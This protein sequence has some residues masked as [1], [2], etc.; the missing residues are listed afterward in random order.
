MSEADIFGQL[1]A[2]VDDK[3]ITV[4]ALRVDGK[5][6]SLQFFRQIP[7]EDW[8]DEELAPRQDATIWGRVHY[9]IANE[10]TEWLLVQ[11]GSQLRRCNVDQP[12]VGTSWMDY[13]E[14]SLDSETKSAERLE[15]EVDAKQAEIE[16]ASLPGVRRIH[17]DS[18]RNL[19]A[20][21]ERVR[22]AIAKCRADIQ[23]ERLSQERSLRRTARI[24]ALGDV[25][26]LFIG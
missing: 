23:S 1:V 25:P 11:V 24:A 18:R 19:V 15:R 10:G 22:A 21:L 7:R 9:R 17:E 8:L 26:Q 2:Q 13:L 12:S 4:C 6:M 14:R 5:K 20:S 3:S 16:E